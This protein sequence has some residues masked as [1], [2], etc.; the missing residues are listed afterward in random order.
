MRSLISSRPV[1]M[2]SCWI[3][4]PARWFS[5]VRLTCLFFLLAGLTGASAVTWA[6][7]PQ[8]QVP[9]VPVPGVP[10]LPEV[11]RAVGGN[12]RELAGARA[13]RTDSLLREDRA[14]LDRDP[15]GELVV[16]AEVIAIDITQSA[17]DKALA[18]KFTVL[19]TED[20]PD[21]GVKLTILQTP[22]GMSASRG[23]KRLRK[24]DPEGSYDFNHVYLDSGE[25]ETARPR[26]SA[27]DPGA[28]GGSVP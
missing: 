6:Q 28:A 19:R 1:V 4:R 25:I 11:T 18:A 27:I 10:A 13:L 5:S 2:V 8:V 3:I 17:L 14:E 20:L 12:L 22:E 16:R 7:L 26:L 21:L 9:N 24:L 23:L 15:R